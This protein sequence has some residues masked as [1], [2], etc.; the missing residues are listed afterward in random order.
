MRSVEEIMQDFNLLSQLDFDVNL[1]AAG[2]FQIRVL[3]ESIARKIYP[4]FFEKNEKDYF[5]EEENGLMENRWNLDACGEYLQECSVTSSTIVDIVLKYAHKS[6]FWDLEYDMTMITEEEQEHIKEEYGV[7]AD[8][9]EGDSPDGLAVMSGFLSHR[10]YS[11]EEGLLS[12]EN[13]AQL[14]HLYE[15]FSIYE[16]EDGICV[17]KGMLMPYVDKCKS[18]CKSLG[19]NYIPYLETAERI[20]L[21]WQNNP[22]KAFLMGEEAWYYA[23]LDGA[24]DSYCYGGMGALKMD[25]RI[26][27]VFELIETI[28]FEVHKIQP[29]LPESLLSMRKAA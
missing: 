6:P 2:V 1:N 14:I 21:N 23:T 29:Y 18:I 26:M 4:S 16:E 3:L 9:V 13:T 10:L 7:E 8:D 15:M 17:I 22:S 5:W 12:G 11:L 24:Y 27:V 28:M 19:L 25:Y 20:L